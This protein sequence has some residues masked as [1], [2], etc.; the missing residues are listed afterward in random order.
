[1]KSKVLCFVVLCFALLING[2]GNKK[3]DKVEQLGY[4]V[5]GPVQNSV[6]EVY[7]LK[8]SPLQIRDRVDSSRTGVDGGFSLQVDKDY[9]G[10]LLYKSVEGVYNDELT[11]NTVLADKAHFP[12]SLIVAKQ[13]DD[14]PNIYLTPLTTLKVELATNSNNQ[15]VIQSFIDSEAF[16][17]RLFG[18]KD[19]G[20]LEF[21]QPVLSSVISS[22]PGTVPYDSFL[23]SKH[24]AT[25]SQLALQESTDGILDSLD[26]VNFF[27]LDLLDGNWDDLIGLS[28]A[29]SFVSPGQ[30]RKAFDT[31]AIEVG[32][33]S[34]SSVLYQ[35]ISSSILTTTSF[36]GFKSLISPINSTEFSLESATLLHSVSS[37]DQLIQLADNFYVSLSKR[38]SKA[39]LFEKMDNLLVP[40]LLSR[41]TFDT[42]DYSQ[43]IAMNLSSQ[44]IMDLV[45]L[46]TSPLTPLRYSL[47]K[48]NNEFKLSVNAI[49]LDMA[50]TAIP[51]SLVSGQFVGS[52]TSTND[53]LFWDTNRNLNCFEAD[54]T[55]LSTCSLTIENIHQFSTIDTIDLNQDKRSDLIFTGAKSASA[56]N[57]SILIYINT[58]NNRFELKQIIADSN[59]Q[60]NS[61]MAQDISGDGYP[62]L[63]IAKNTGFLEYYEQN[64]KN[65]LEFQQSIASKT[66]EKVV[67]IPFETNGRAPVDILYVFESENQTK[68]HGVKKISQQ[69]LAKTT[70]SIDISATSLSFLASPYTS[71][72]LDDLL[73]TDLSASQIL[74]LTHSQLK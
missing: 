64:S 59:H 52:L 20:L 72:S 50:T 61:I 18:F 3:K 17:N 36:E 55:K 37:P 29:E 51:G 5:K 22:S 65:Q 53:L 54:A 47:A 62:D 12:F 73:Y 33:I 21:K 70:N 67:F 66:N 69:K 11:G 45:F 31:V 24:L 9:R 60:V 14:L 43:V 32:G 35:S 57:T 71:D 23:M 26:A 74:V 44:T 63:L 30:F 58:G 28:G 1:M 56:A 8:G 68:I 46:T 27:Q 34:T 40:S 16:I 42:P 49:E 7:E 10:Y 4:V 13:S 6:I 39:I 19:P 15:I 48:S 25:F 2:C 41:Q 38:L